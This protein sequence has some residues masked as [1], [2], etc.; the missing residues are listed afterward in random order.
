M[1]WDQIYSLTFQ[2]N[3]TKAGFVHRVL[4]YFDQAN[5]LLLYSYLHKYGMFYNPILF[6]V[7]Q[8]AITDEIIR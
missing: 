4:A 8:E 5:L 6:G 7:K 1:F 2:E 3:Q